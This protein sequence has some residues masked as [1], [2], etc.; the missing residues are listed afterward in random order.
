M[1]GGGGGGEAPSVASS[2]PAFY[3]A[4]WLL[5]EK[6][7]RRGR[8]EKREREGGWCATR[9]SAIHVVQQLAIVAIRVF[10]PAT[11]PST[12][13]P[14]GIS[15]LLS[16]SRSID[17][18]NRVRTLDE[19]RP[20]YPIAHSDDRLLLHQ[21]LIFLYPNALSRVEIFAFLLLRPSTSQFALWRAHGSQHR[22]REIRS[23]RRWLS[24][25]P[26]ELSKELSRPTCVEFAFRPFDPPRF[27]RARNFIRRA[28]CSPAV[29]AGPRVSASR[30]SRIIFVVNRYS[31]LA[32]RFITEYLPAAATPCESRLRWKRTATIIARSELGSASS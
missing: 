4:A 31:R 23:D 2:L 27:S 16:P 22:R 29:L 14:V 19:R 24:S 32:I 7:E 26:R 13:D 9:R 5:W 20:R 3:C 11:S 10:T 18:V 25:G 1:S 17:R 21:D 6:E 12:V 15:R 30:S 8:E 28:I